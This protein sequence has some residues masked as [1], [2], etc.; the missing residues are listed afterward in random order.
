MRVVRS[1]HKLPREAVDIQSLEAFK[2]RLEQGVEQT[3]LVIAV[4]AHGRGVET[5]QSPR[6][7]PKP[8]WDSVKM[9]AVRFQWATNTPRAPV[10][11]TVYGLPE[12]P[13]AQPMGAQGSLVANTQKT[14]SLWLKG[15]CWKQGALPQAGLCSSGAQD[16]W[17]GRGTD[18]SW[19]TKAKRRNKS[20]FSWQDAGTLW[21][22][23]P[24]PLGCA[25]TG[26]SRVELTWACLKMCMM[27]MVRPSPKM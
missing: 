1:W 12:P 22:S 24:D 17:A 27:N 16:L 11:T 5:R 25:S 14:Q 8:L 21:P 10:Q 2:A 7:L 26:G 19:K 9:L 6:S 15:Y 13:A 23:W 20:T 18:R 4:S 3:H